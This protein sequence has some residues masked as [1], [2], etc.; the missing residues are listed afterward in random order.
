MRIEEI[1]DKENGQREK[2]LQHSANLK[3]NLYINPK[4]SSGKIQDKQ[5]IK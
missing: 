1:L 4:F 3:I 5:L 2:C